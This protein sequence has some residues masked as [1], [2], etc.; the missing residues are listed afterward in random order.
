MN[1]FRE[2]DKNIKAYNNPVMTDEEIK[3]LDDVRSV[4]GKTTHLL[5]S[6]HYKFINDWAPKQNINSNN[7]LVY[8]SG[9]TDQ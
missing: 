4:G 3:L 5:L 8:Y 2:F 6:D 1:H 7:K 9:C